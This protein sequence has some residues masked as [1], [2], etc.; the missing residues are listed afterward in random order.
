[1]ILVPI[2]YN[3]DNDISTS[4]QRFTVQENTIE[5]CYPQVNGLAIV[6]WMS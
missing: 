4:L 2:D 6:R 5:E 1:M 3:E